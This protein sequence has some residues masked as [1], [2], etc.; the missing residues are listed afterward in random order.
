VRRRRG[1]DEEE[2]EE[3]EEEGAVEEKLKREDR[4][5]FTEVSANDK[6]VSVADELAENCKSANRRQ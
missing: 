3:E 6:D 4:A 5:R 1:S 2:E